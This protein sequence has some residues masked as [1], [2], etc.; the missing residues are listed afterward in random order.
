MTKLIMTSFRSKH[1]KLGLA[2]FAA[3]SVA[4]GFTLFGSSE[5]S[6]HRHDL[7]GRED[8]RW[9]E[10]VAAYRSYHEGRSRLPARRNLIRYSSTDLFAVSPDY[11][12]DMLEILSG[13]TDRVLA[14]RGNQKGRAA[15]REFLR[16]EFE[17]HGFEVSLHEY[18]TGVNLVAER[19]G[20]SGKFLIVSAHYDSMNNPG[21]DD[22]GSGTV[23][24][25]ATAKLLAD[26]VLE[27][28]VRFVA[29]DE[30]E[31]GLIGSRAYVDRL[32]ASGDKPRILGDVQLEML[33][34]NG[35]KDG[36]FHVVS[37][38]RKDSEFLADA[39]VEAVR[40][41]E[42]GLKITEACTDRSDHAP[43]W[44]AG[45]PAIVISQNFFGGDSN[46]CYHRT[47]DQID[48][49]HLDYFTK[50][51]ETAANAVLLLVSE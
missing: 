47:C 41:L 46:P 36:K 8:H 10:D 37:C 1:S 33:G 6:A 51:A 42:N 13:E 49:M 9:D 12:V 29:F 40:G 24:M 50:M 27:H 5:V 28:G 16:H 17:R 4:L 2:G 26:K 14:N 38:N 7:D 35:R 15:A 11:V 22:D 39:V 25:L 43:F 23:A 3:L 21:A 31:L 34:Y 44:K 20:R 45:I 18:R 19:K 48:R 32:I 30:E